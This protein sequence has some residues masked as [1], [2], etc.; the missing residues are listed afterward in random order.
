MLSFSNWEVGKRDFTGGGKNQA[1]KRRVLD[2][3]VDLVTS[4]GHERKTNEDLKGG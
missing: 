2:L 1:G 3:G 4:A